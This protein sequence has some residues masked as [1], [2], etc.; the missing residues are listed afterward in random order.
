[1]NAKCIE[2]RLPLFALSICSRFSDI[3]DRDVPDRDSAICDRQR[4]CHA[5]RQSRDQL[6]GL[7]HWYANVHSHRAVFFTANVV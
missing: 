3:P 1:M 6:I 4:Q 7:R 2:A 5:L